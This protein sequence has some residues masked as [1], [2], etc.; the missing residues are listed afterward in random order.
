MLE[1]LE[2]ENFRIPAEFQTF[3]ISEHCLQSET[4]VPA[5]KGIFDQL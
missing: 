1:N 2:T 3:G 4:W 5:A